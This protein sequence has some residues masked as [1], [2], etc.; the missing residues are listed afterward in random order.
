MVSLLDEIARLFV[1]AWVKG[2]ALA[3]VVIAILLIWPLVLVGMGFLLKPVG[4]LTVVPIVTIACLL[5][6]LLGSKLA[7]IE[8]GFARFIARVIIPYLLIGLYCSFVPLSESVRLV[9][10][11]ALI[12]YLILFLFLGGRTGWGWLA[13]V[14]LIAYSVAFFPGTMKT[15]RSLAGTNHD[16]R[17]GSA[18]PTDADLTKEIK[19][20]LY[21]D[22]LA[23]G[24]DLRIV[25]INRVATLAGSVPSNA[26]RYEALKVA[27]GTA[28]ISKVDDRIVVEP[29]P[30]NSGPIKRG[31][32]K[33]DQNQLPTS[34]ADLWAQVPVMQAS[35]ATDK[36][37]LGE[38]VLLRW[39]ATNADRVILQ[40]A[41]RQIPVPLSGQYQIQPNRAGNGEADFIAF[42]S[43]GRQ[44]TSQVNYQVLPPLPPAAPVIQASAATD[45]V[46]LGQEV[47]LQW[48]AQNA[49]RVVLQFAGR[50]AV[51]P[52]SGHY[53]IQPS[54]VGPGEADLIAIGSD[55]QQ[56]TT[57]VNFQVL[58]HA[59]PSVIILNPA[60]HASNLAPQEVVAFLIRRLMAQ[61][62]EILS[63]PYFLNSVEAAGRLPISSRPD[64]VV[65]ANLE[66]IPG[67]MKQSTAGKVM[68]IFVRN[69]PVLYDVTVDC[70]ATIQMTR[71]SDDQI[72]AQGLSSKSFQRNGVQAARYNQTISE[73]SQQGLQFVL[74][75]AL[76]QLR[77]PG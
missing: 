59:R 68:G 8:L 23:E 63:R 56:A 19:V 49:A 46:R 7:I 51:L 66:A 41:G 72:V 61:G 47:T 32:R 1:A 4:A 62:Y 6:I 70:S 36:V 64:Y 14:S 60:I 53:D 43:N 24:S 21:S 17:I 2:N 34:P 69:A 37:H 75:S 22:P 65:Q 57:Q 15:I 73:L 55:G 29:P 54:E 10:S 30:V 76:D 58:P 71:I 25:V 45:K 50:Q 11:V 26:A 13:A 31:E 42:G 40:Y 38:E 16:R 33:Q 9:P 39:T 77:T 12:W 48:T 27:T 44:T 28:G 52:L 5:V 18:V 35:A 67:P 74:Q 3:R 20:Q